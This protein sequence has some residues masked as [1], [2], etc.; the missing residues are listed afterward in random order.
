MR[1]SEYEEYE[2]YEEVNQNQDAEN[3]QGWSG[4]N[5]FSALLTGVSSIPPYALFFAYGIDIC[6]GL[7]ENALTRSIPGWAVGGTLALYAAYGVAMS[8]GNLNDNSEKK[9][10]AANDFISD[11]NEPDIESQIDP[12]ETT[13]LKQKKKSCCTRLYWGLTPYQAFI[14]GGDALGHIADY[15]AK[16]FF[17]ASLAMSNL[18]TPRW[19]QGTVY[20][21]ATATGIICSKSEISTCINAYR[22]TNGANYK[23]DDY[24]N[25]NKPNGWTILTLIV[26][27]FVN[28]TDVT[29]ALAMLVDGFFNMHGSKL[30]VSFVALGVGS[31]FG[32]Y[33]GFSSG[34]HY[35]KKLNTNHQGSSTC[36]HHHHHHQS[37]HTNNDDVIVEVE[38]ID[39][40]TEQPINSSNIDDHDRPKSK[41]LKKKMRE[42]LKK[43]KA[44][45]NSFFEGLNGFDK[46]LLPGDFLY[47]TIE[48]GSPIVYFIFLVAGKKIP[49]YGKLI[50]QLGTYGISLFSA[51]PYTNSCVVNAKEYNENQERQ[52]IANP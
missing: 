28:S 46:A 25:N 38:L 4:K 6:F 18:I 24:Q 8:H 42:K 12:T 1:P 47:H 35:H 17:V 44:N 52:L 3:N 32:L 21:L 14:M 29:Y 30:A 31:G 16:I 36:S 41:P 33:A 20:A 19:A 2:E 11:A 39:T 7:T 26:E 51:I 50:T 27:T 5:K 43:C 10:A 13:P 34:G 23:S 45:C 48:C 49:R 40:S 22:R 9:K 15:A 37:H